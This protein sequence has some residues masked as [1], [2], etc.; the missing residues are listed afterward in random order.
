MSRTAVRKLATV[1]CKFL[2]NFQNS[3]L[4]KKSFAPTKI[5][6]FLRLIKHM[7]YFAGV[8]G[9]AVFTL[10]LAFSGCNS[11]AAIVF[12]T[13][14][15]AIHGAVSTGP[16]ASFVDLGPN[17]ASIILGISGIFTVI[18][19][20]IS[21]IIV[22]LLTYKNVRYYVLRFLMAFHKKIYFFQQTISQW[23]IVY[24]ISF[25]QLLV[26]GILHLLF[27]KSDI[28]PWNDPKPKEK[29]LEVIG[30]EK[31]KMLANN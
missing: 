2:L 30:G 5:L 15:T 28:Q 16:L 29:E 14:A 6:K 4:Q 7:K 23:Q 3:P 1:V 17:F 10:G 11:T 25:V 13:A 26:C 9:Q 19:G 22:G 12:L 24:L 18:P 31:E 20:F 27:S 21:P 8:L